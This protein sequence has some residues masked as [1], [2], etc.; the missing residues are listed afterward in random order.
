MTKPSRSFQRSINVYSNW[1]FTYRID[2]VS[3]YLPIDHFIIKVNMF[4]LRFAKSIHVLFYDMNMLC[5]ECYVNCMVNLR[6]GTCSKFKKKRDTSL[7][8]IYMKIFIQIPFFFIKNV[9]FEIY[10]I[11]RTLRNTRNFCIKQFRDTK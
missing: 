8:N 11:F 5:Y 3:T 10:I 2:S 4:F 9:Q 7:T 6:Y 1:F